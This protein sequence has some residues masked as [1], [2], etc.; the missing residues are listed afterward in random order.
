MFPS[1]FTDELGL[2]LVDAVP[3]LRDWGLAHCDLRARVLGKHFEELAPDELK[4]VRNLLGDAGLKVGCLESSLAKVHLPDAER[5]RAEARK[6]EAIIRAA[7]VLDCRLVRSFFFWQ[8][9]KEEAGSLGDRSDALEQTL[10]FFAP[11]ARRAREAGL[12]LA[13]ENCGVTPDEVL[14]F[15]DAVAIPSWGL[16]WDV[17]N[18]WR[19]KPDTES[20]ED[21]LRRLALRAR[22]LHVKA[23]GAVSGLAPVEIPYELVLQ[24]ADN[25]GVRG[26]VSAE[27]HNPD[28]AGDDREM[29]RRVVEVIRRAWPSAA[30]G[31]LFGTPRSTATRVRTYEADPVR[32]VVIGLG[33]G[34]NRAQQ[35]VKTPGA[36]LVG[37]CDLRKERAERT[38]QTCAVP[39]TLDFREWLERDDVEVVYVMTETGRHAEI[40]LEAL[41]A[42]KHV[43]TTK[44]ME[45]SLEACDRMIC[46]AEKKGL[47]LGVDFGRR[48]EPGPLSL[49]AAVEQKRFGRLLN[50][51][52]ELKIL[53]TMEYFRA[54][55]GWRGTRRW[56][57]GGVLSNQSIHHIDELV[58]V[59]GVPARVRC[60]IWTQAHEIEAE[61]LGSAVWE[62]DSGLVVTY[63]ATSSYPHATWYVRSEIQGTDGAIFLAAGGP[64]EQPFERWFL[65]GAWGTPPPEVKMESEWLNAA[66]NF[67]AALR[68]GAPLVC[69]GRDGRR[70]QAVLDAMYRSAYENDGG[71]T[72][73]TPE[74]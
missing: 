30:P 57:G 59:L 13:F 34:H 67:A 32:F 14:A 45:A 3:F 42:G 49:R 50:G 39:Y 38:S 18:G 19:C 8:P 60:S 44:P 33:M 2:D 15:L 23:R 10:D 72:A 58:F 71:W 41:E 65:D 52:M 36:T 21:Y 12:I 74:L 22:L 1:I 26:P 35:V 48:F 47:L 40:A 73:V 17:Y 69:S 4:R 43:L 28:R 6:L 63:F 7:D 62:Y 56:D 11:L 27:T 25:A 55:G 24:T 54:N 31:G 46:A 29:S 64:F 66:D 61:D 51:T 70:T 37:V 53:R 5:R 20:V 68:T 9:P 16:A